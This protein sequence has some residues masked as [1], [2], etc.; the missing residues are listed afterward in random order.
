MDNFFANMFRI[1]QREAGTQGVPATTAPTDAQQQKSEVGGGTFE[2]RVV[3]ARS[4]Q[5]A[6]TISAVY[7]AVELRAKTIGQMLMQYQQKDHDK[8]N[9]VMAMW[10]AG[11]RMNYLLQ[12]RP[13]PIMSAS[14]LFE[15]MMVQRLMLGNAFVYIERDEYGEPVSLWLARSGGYNPLNG[16]Y[17]LTYLSDAGPKTVI[18]D[19]DN[20]LHWPNTYRDPDGFWGISTLQYAFETLSLIKTEN[21]QALETA[22]KGGRIKGFIGEEKPAQGAGTLAFGLINKSAG[23]DYAKELS[24]KVYQQDITFMRGLD[25]WIPLSMTAQD[26]Q[27]IE[28]LQ[29]SQDDVARFF[30]VPRPLLMMDSNSH[31]TTP[32]AATQE[33]LSRTIQPDARELEDEFDGKLLTI[34]DFGKRRFH[35]CEQPLFRL[36]PEAAAKVAKAKMEAG[37]CTVNEN[38]ADFDMPTVE[39]GDIVYLSTNLMELGSDKGRSNGGGRPAQGND[40]GN[41]NQNTEEQ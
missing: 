24:Q 7:R 5:A 3:Y 11:K 25:K 6:L 33:F 15:Q 19:R 36:D 18:T 31:Y 30:A 32:T 28:L 38:R 8:G 16:T 34:D 14:S 17:A 9:F 40:N 23:D 10:G 35:L 21:A 1:R 22:A 12:K 29:M 2:E 4:P 20:V 41:D 37:I 27:I 13:N 39:K 26:M